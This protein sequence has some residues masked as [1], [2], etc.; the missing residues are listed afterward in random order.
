MRQSI[1]WKTV[2]CLLLVGGW[3]APSASVTYLDDCAHNGVL[4]KSELTVGYEG[5]GSTNGNFVP[6][7]PPP[8]V[9]LAHSVPPVQ[10]LVVNPSPSG[11]AA[12]GPVTRLP[13]GGGAMKDQVQGRVE[14]FFEF[15]TPSGTRPTD[16][17]RLRAVGVG[18]SVASFNSAGNEAA[19]HVFAHATA[20]FYNGLTPISG[21]AT[22]CVGVIW[23][24]Q[25]RG[26]LP[27]ETLMELR[28]VQDPTGAPIVVANQV[29]GDPP[30]LVT[31]VPDQGYL[32]EFRYE[33]HVPFGMDPNF[34]ASVE[35][36]VLP[37]A[38]VPA[39]DGVERGVLVG[40]LVALAAFAIVGMRARTRSIA[41]EEQGGH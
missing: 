4:L 26:L 37:P 12:I 18:S 16:T 27:F 17:F 25:M 3:A 34:D 7:S 22:T 31:L 6:G 10:T 36:N 8:P 24:A 41:S 23:L 30:L 29:P 20:E 38:T 19:A 39:M 13:L 15:G 5:I 14:S 32:I 21:P 2:A 1:P 40:L 35:F 33:Y 28:V 9:D 11:V